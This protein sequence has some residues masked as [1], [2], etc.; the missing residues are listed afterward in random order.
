MPHGYHLSSFANKQAEKQF[1]LKDW[2]NHTYYFSKKTFQNG[3]SKQDKY[4]LN[5]LHVATRN[6]RKNTQISQIKRNLPSSAGL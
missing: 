4:V 5:S 6:G 1:K 3:R 2:K